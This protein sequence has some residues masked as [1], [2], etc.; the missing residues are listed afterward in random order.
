MILENP[1]QMRTFLEVSE[2]SKVEEWEGDL[3][4]KK[5]PRRRKQNDTVRGIWLPIIM[6]EL[7]GSPYTKEEAQQVYNELKM[8][9]E[10]VVEKVN[11][12]TGEVRLFPKDT[13]DLESGLYSQ[14]MEM[15]ARNVA[16]N[17]QI[18]LPDPKPELSK[19]RI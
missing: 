19:R 10:W 9:M 14:W 11:K 2:T 5:K 1:M 16:M 15:F 3:Y 6:E 7:Y 12:K 13:H 17:H 8:E 4:P 18:F